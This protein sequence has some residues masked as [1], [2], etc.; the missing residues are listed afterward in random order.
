MHDALSQQ[1]I[2]GTSSFCISWGIFNFLFLHATLSF[3]PSPFPLPT[4]L[5]VMHQCGIQSLSHESFPGYV[6]S[7]TQYKPYLGWG[8]SGF[9]R[10][11]SQQGMWLC[12]GRTER[13]AVW[14]HSQETAV[15]PPA[16]RSAAQG[17]LWNTQFTHIYLQRLCGI[18]SSQSGFDCMLWDNGDDL[19]R[20]TELWQLRINLASITWQGNFCFHGSTQV[21]SSSFTRSWVQSQISLLYKTFALTCMLTRSQTAPGPR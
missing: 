15:V 9:L 16:W 10:A 8:R 13:E 19:R 7:S 12:R 18:F 14:L 1:L 5:P 20:N 21:L 17:H 3:P 11:A 2:N 4:A 6:P